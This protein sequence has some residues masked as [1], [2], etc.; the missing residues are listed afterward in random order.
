M[1]ILA[2]VCLKDYSQ[3][4]HQKQSPLRLEIREGLILI[5]KGLK[6]QRFLVESSSPYNTPILR[7]RKE[8]NKWRLVQ[9]LQLIPLHHIVPKP[10]TFLA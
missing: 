9:V 7:V 1:A 10:Y 6:E 2:K 8:S 5:F 4:F 3:F